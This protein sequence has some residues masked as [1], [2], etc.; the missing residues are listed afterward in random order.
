M[1]YKTCFYSTIIP[2]DFI[3]ENIS[4]RDKIHIAIKWIIKTE[5]EGLIAER[6]AL[7]KKWKDLADK[8]FT[9]AFLEKTKKGINKKQVT[10]NLS[11]RT[12]EH[13]YYEVI[14]K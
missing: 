10:V 7:A 1:S 5:C 8:G 12:V 4:N 13:W 11:D 6:G 14:E 3:M 2:P 9:I